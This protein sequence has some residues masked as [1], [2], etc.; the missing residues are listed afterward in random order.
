[1]GR[2][3]NFVIR[4]DLGSGEILSKIGKN[5]A[6]EP[7]IIFYSQQKPSG[8]IDQFKLDVKKLLG[9]V[10]PGAEVAAQYSQEL[11]AAVP[12]GIKG[13][14][15]EKNRPSSLTPQALK[16]ALNTIEVGSYDVKGSKDLITTVN[17]EFEKA[18]PLEDAAGKGLWINDDGKISAP[19]KPPNH[20]SKFRPYVSHPRLRDDSESAATT[21]DKSSGT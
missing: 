8:W 10:R 12:D 7:S 5:K 13:I 21:N 9:I 17:V 20:T 15:G 14:T 3:I 1:M 2:T 18:S 16:F 19:L 11:G 6:G 4:G